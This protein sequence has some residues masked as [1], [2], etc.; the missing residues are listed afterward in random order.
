MYQIKSVDIKSAAI[1]S[2]MTSTLLGL[3]FIPFYF[4]ARGVTFSAGA[5]EAVVGGVMSVILAIIVPLVYGAIGFV[6]G[7]LMAWV[8]NA[9]AN[10]FGGLKGELQP[11]Y[12]TRTLGS[13]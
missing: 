8:Y 9:V 3:L 6:V 5:R 1:V 2:G 13:R 10:R 4:L 7:A 12:S 11:V